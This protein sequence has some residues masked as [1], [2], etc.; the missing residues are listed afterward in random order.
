MELYFLRHG[1]A[2]DAESW[3]GTDFD[4][5]LTDDGRERMAREA[6]AIVQLVPVIDRIVTSPLV[7]ARQTAEIVAIAL[8]ATD[9]LVEDERLGAGFDLD[10]LAGILRAHDDAAALMLVGHEPALSATIGRLIGGAAVELKKGSLARV[11]LPDAARLAGELIWLVP[12]KVLLSK[13]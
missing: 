5:P 4:R 13:P 8:K 10:R 7:R 1:R 2:A 3:R 6:K 9:R 12:P 11:D